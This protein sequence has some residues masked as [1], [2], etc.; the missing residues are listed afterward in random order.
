MKIAFFGTKPYDHPWFEKL[1]PESGQ[2]ITFFRPR[3]TKETAP[4]ADGHRAVC[5]FVNDEL[6]RDTLEILKK[7]GVELILLRCA[8]YN[9][10]DLEAAHELGLTVLRVPGYSPEA[11]AEH[12]MALA[13][14]ANRRLHKAYNKVRDNDFSL[15]GLT[16]VN[17]Y[18]K[19]AG[20]VGTGKI[21]QAMINIC[22]GFGMEV[23]AYDPYPV[24]GLGVKYVPLKELLEQSDLI[25][26]HC[27]LFPETYH[28]IDSKAIECMKDGVILVNTSRGG[29]IK[30]EDLINGIKAGKFHAVALDVYEEESG[31]V[32]EDRSDDILD[33]TT[34]ARL[35][36][37]PNVLLT[38]HQGFLTKEALRTIAEVTLDNAAAYENN[39]VLK[40]LVS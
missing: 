34:T 25:S 18:G 35:L 9:N 3:L 30:T 10:V 22:R 7:A 16:G 15:T 40:N 19:T 32:Y 5:A 14:A 11:V 24:S 29:L 21:G 6:G 27:P 31:L 39:E 20:I 26:L 38:S 1:S 2:E 36:S 28:I 23:L 17:L 33:H 8:G 12:A 4:L 37:F 13:M